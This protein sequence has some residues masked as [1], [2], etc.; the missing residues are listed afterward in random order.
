MPV[1]TKISAWIERCGYPKAAGT[2]VLP[3]GGRVWN[4]EETALLPYVLLLLFLVV[5]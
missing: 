3:F 4:R 2:A 1:K 5:S